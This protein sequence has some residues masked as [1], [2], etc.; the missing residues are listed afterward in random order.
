[1]EAEPIGFAITSS[2][3][4]HT[5]TMTAENTKSPVLGKVVLT[6]VDA[7]DETVKLPG[8]VFKLEERAADG[9]WTDL[10]GYCLL[11]TSRC[12]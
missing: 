2:M 10:P 9:T 5:A 1:M 12:V 6:K 11:Y 4:D 3:P 7:D 8:A